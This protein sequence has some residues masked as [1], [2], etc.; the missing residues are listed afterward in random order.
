MLNC[1]NDA[2]VVTETKAAAGLIASRALR[3]KAHPRMPLSS[4]SR[5]AGH[6]KLAIILLVCEIG[7]TAACKRWQWDK[8]VGWVDFG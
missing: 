7:T 8:E 4:A 1:K 2:E 3:S 6:L 5:T